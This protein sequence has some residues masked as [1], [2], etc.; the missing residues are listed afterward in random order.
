MARK[1]RVLLPGAIYHITSRGNDRRPIFKSDDDRRRFLERLAASAQTYD[2]RIYLYCL[3]DNHVHLLLE[4]PH[5]NLDRFMGSLLTGYTVYFNLRHDRAGHLMQGRYGAQLVQGTEYLLKLS[6][7]IHLNP[8]H[9]KEWTD[10]PLRQRLDHLHR[11]AWSSFPEYAGLTKPCGFLCTQPILELTAHFG[12]GRETTRYRRYV[13]A[14]LADSDEEFNAL[15]N[16]RGV[17]IG[18]PAF[19]HEVKELHCQAAEEQHRA[20]DISFRQIRAYQPADDVLRAVTTMLHL[21]E[22]ASSGRRS[23]P[24]E[25]GFLAWA[26]QHHAGLTQ[27]EIAPIIG[28]QTGAAVSC[29]IKRFHSAP[30]CAEWKQDLYLLFK[31]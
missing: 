21:P 2:V 10:R 13:E 5:P 18:S 23:Y 31:G 30:V 25:R 3:M 26:L 12:R 17:A 14:G 4:T 22:L 11:Y 28:L 8:V 16:N 20:E 27:R 1:P 9:T 6:R 24:L 15:M 19:I 7:Y 29:A